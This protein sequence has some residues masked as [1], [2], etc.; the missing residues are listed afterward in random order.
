MLVKVCLK[1]INDGDTYRDNNDFIDKILIDIN[2]EINGNEL[3][4]I[5]QKNMDDMGFTCILIKY[6]TTNDMFK[7]SPNMYELIAFSFLFLFYIV[8][9]YSQENPKYNQRW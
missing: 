5:I 8:Y 1:A 4:N 2:N 7:I 3:Q 9:K 6:I